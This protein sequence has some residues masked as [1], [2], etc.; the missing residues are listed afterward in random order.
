MP[1]EKLHTVQDVVDNLKIGGLILSVGQRQQLYAACFRL[2]Q[3]LKG[4][5]DRTNVTALK[6]R[7][8]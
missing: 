7:R 3:D 6:T 8:K 5:A 4:A 2:T 1:R